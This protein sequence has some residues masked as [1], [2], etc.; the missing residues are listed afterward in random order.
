[1]RYLVCVSGERVIPD[2]APGISVNLPGGMRFQILEGWDG[3]TPFGM[4]L[5][6]VGSRCAEVLV[7]RPEWQ[8]VDAAEIAELERIAR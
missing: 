7:Q 5:A 8:I 2:P 1:M 3:I 4:Q 6:Y